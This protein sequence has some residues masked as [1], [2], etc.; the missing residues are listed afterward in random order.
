MT[1][2][3]SNSNISVFGNIPLVGL[4]GKKMASGQPVV[5][6]FF[7]FFGK[8]LF[9]IKRNILSNRASLYLAPRVRMRRASG[10]I[11]DCFSSTSH[12]DPK[13]KI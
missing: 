1:L 13:C 3:A 7:F 2:K 8:P 9:Y 10:T 11:L 5:A 6:I 4:Q 12:P